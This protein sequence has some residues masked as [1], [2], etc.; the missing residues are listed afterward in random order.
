MRKFFYILVIVVGSMQII[1]YISGVKALR[2]LGAVT[3]SSPLPLVFGEVRGVETFASDFYVSY[4]TTV[5]RDTMTRITPQMYSQLQGPY[6]R[7][8]VYGAAISYGPVLSESIWQPILQHGIC[9]RSL[10]RE[11]GLDT[12]GSNYKIYIKTRTAGSDS[13]WTLVPS[14]SK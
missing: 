12:L 2:G 14:C 6:N 4:T 5:G 9:D 1:G 11:M 3:C 13:S 10:L 8:N 7:R